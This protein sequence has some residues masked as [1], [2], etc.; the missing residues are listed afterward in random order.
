M[1]ANLGFAVN[2]EHHQGALRLFLFFS[3]FVCLLFF[4]LVSRH[5]DFLDAD[6][7]GLQRV[8]IK[9]DGGGSIQVV[10]TDLSCEAGPRCPP[11]GNTESTVGSWAFNTLPEKK[12][13]IATN[14]PNNFIDLERSI[15][16]LNIS[17]CGRGTGPNPSSHSRLSHDPGVNGDF[18]LGV[19][20][21][22]IGA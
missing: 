14:G 21:S 19:C 2:S 12:M 6:H 16:Y 3:L 7:F 15:T 18:L 4:L 8:A 22:G 11:S 20:R 9:P 17:R 5:T 13:K 10:S 1:S